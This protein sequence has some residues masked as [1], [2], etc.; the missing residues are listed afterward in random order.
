MK[1]TGYLIIF[2]IIIGFG[3]KKWVKEEPLSD[4][5]LDQ[6]FKSKYDADAA[7]AGM[8]GQ[9]QQL[10]F[11]E[12]QFNNRYTFWGDARS[13]NMERQAQYSNS[14][15]TEIHYNSLTANNN[16]ADWTPLYVAIGRANINLAKFP[17]INKIA[18]PAQQL[19]LATLNS[20]MAQC[21][22]MR[23]ICYFYIARVW[24]AAPIRTEPFLQ[25]SSNI[26]C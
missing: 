25:Y 5:T 12:S 19:T 23:A 16:F 4:G 9:F 24:G 8:Y 11:G 18:P 13:D 3:C 22:A 7:M 15:T 6:F 17:E 20:Y 10:M 2:A 1:I 14:S 21:Y 26:S